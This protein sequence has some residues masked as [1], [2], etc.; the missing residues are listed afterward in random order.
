MM[1]LVLVLILV[2]LFYKK[3]LPVLDVYNIHIFCNIWIRASKMVS[4]SVCQLYFSTSFI[5]EG[6]VA[7]GWWLVLSYA[8]TGM[9]QSWWWL[10]LSLTSSAPAVTIEAIM[11]FHLQRLQIAFSFF[12]NC[13]IALGTIHP[14]L[15]KLQYF[16]P[17]S[18]WVDAKRPGHKT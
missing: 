7:D 9:A 15:A 14:V 10:M 3:K 6:N 17:L 5:V 11:L 13:L 12:I 4:F 18:M 1:I 16:V 2:I 8:P